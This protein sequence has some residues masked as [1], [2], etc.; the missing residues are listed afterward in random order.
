[1]IDLENLPRHPLVEE[2]VGEL[3]V[4]CD[5]DSPDY[6]R[7]L[8]G[9]Y[10]SKLAANMR[11]VVATGTCEDA[12]PVNCFAV[13]MAPT[14][15]GKGRSIAY[16]EKGVMAGFRR[17]FNEDTLP[18]LAEQ[19]LWRLAAEKAAI[20]GDSEENERARLE[21]HYRKAGPY[22]PTMR[23]A[24][25][26]M[27]QQM[28]GKLL[29]ASAG[30]ITIQ[31]DE[32]G[33]N[34][35]KQGVAEALNVFFE[36]YDMGQ[37]EVSATKNSEDNMRLDEIEGF[38]PANLLMFGVATRVFD[39]AST[40]ASFMTTLETG[41]ARRCLYAWGERPARRAPMT[42][43]EK[44]RRLAR[45]RQA[46]KSSGLKTRF[47][48][49]ADPA[50]IDW[51]VVEP[52]PVGVRRTAY[53]LACRARAEAFPIHD[54]I[55]RS[56]MEHRHSKA[57]KLAGALAF[58]DE[59]L[60][61]TMDHLLAAI[62]IVEDSGRAFQR[63]LNRDR[64][65]VKLAKYLASCGSEVTHADL[66]EE[67]AFYPRSQGGRQ[68]MLADA[69]AWGYRNTIILRR[70][71]EDGIE[72]LSGEALQATDPGA[73]ILSYSDDA[74]GGYATEPAPFG[75]LDVLARQPGMHWCNHRF[76]GGLRAE[77]TVIPGFNLVVADVDGGTSLDLVHGILREH[78]FMTCT[79][80]HH[81]PGAHRFRLVLPINYILEME[82]D[83][84]QAFI[85]NLLAWLPF[86][87]DPAAGQRSTTWPTHAQARCHINAGRL[88]D[89][90][91]FIPRTSRNE[92]FLK[93]MKGLRALDPLERWFAQRMAVGDRDAP[94]IRYA[95]FLVDQVVGIDEV[96]ARVLRLNG[97]LPEPLEETEL[98]S[99]IL[100]M[101]G[102]T[103]IPGA[104]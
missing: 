85:G 56:E 76:A 70:R 88:V 10:L 45:A 5:A 4:R 47:A 54:E 99:T 101:A 73:M 53:E 26:A 66:Q 51:T 59:S 41:Y 67:L 24:T 61:L 93:E 35:E 2:M 65:H 38:T 71:H 98:R 57:L 27:L 46:S 74:A 83:D 81:A 29:L 95:R 22:L 14:G 18:V 97:R 96:E 75:R 11:V 12:I 44:Y 91:P 72:F 79:T 6:F 3:M 32:I 1:M 55:R 60:E 15:F 13:A 82:A 31:V 68:L 86:P 17:R 9:F 94:A 21:T 28:R 102:K 49:L 77:E 23:G 100:G 8:S 69:M 87:C 16:F 39:G 58:A 19:N 50:R 90:L 34:L 7:V 20:S 25:G 40:E 89:A 80:E 63:M 36:L 84:Y 42:P 48:R 33:N 43:E 92:V 52:E 103:T 64:P 30:A 104:I 78:A 62:G 37:M